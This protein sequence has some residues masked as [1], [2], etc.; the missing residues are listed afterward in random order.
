M[1]QGFTNLLA[2]ARNGRW[3]V[4]FHCLKQSPAT[5]VIPLEAT[6]EI[7]E[8]LDGILFATCGKQ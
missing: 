4:G 8:R 2:H 1:Y 5:L 7:L 3:F 6:N